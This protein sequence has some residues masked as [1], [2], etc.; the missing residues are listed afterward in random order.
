M[1]TIG[2]WCICILCASV[3][4][5]SAIYTVYNDWWIPRKEKQ[6]WNHT[7]EKCSQL[8]MNRFD[9]YYDTYNP[10]SD[11]ILTK[12]LN[13]LSASIYVDMNNVYVGNGV[14]SYW[15]HHACPIVIDK[16]TK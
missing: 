2:M 16:K 15:T 5:W 1:E 13:I 10:Y 6:K 14:V 3:V 12:I 11:S 7:C 4:A 9:F 8:G